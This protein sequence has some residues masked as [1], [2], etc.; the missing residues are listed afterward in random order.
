MLDAMDSIEENQEPIPGAIALCIFCGAIA[1]L[2]NELR[3][4]R[5]TEQVLNR[6]EK[7]EE[8]RKTYMQFS[9]GRQYLMNEF[10]LIR[11]DKENNPDN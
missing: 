6:L 10:N 11:P 7:N 5:P 9:W 1:I 4:I 8:F 3:M 2:D